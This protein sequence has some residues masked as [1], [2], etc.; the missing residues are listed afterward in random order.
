MKC[1]VDTNIFN[2]LID[3]TLSTEDLP[4]Q[5]KFFATHIQSDEPNATMDVERRARLL[6]RFETLVDEVVP[7]ESLVLD[8]SRLDYCRLGDSDLYGTIKV[9]LDRRNGG[10]ANNVQDALIAEVAITNGFT[11]FAADSDLA[12]AAKIHGCSVRHYPK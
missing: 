12:E 1:M 7:T 5:A 4:A 10:K 3:G 2:R 6:G 11:L 9:D 8:L